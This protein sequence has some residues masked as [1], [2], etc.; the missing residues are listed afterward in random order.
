MGNSPHDAATDA[1]LSMQDEA[2]SQSANDMRHDGSACVEIYTTHVYFQMPVLSASDLVTVQDGAYTLRHHCSLLHH[3]LMASIIPWISAQYLIE[4]G[5]LTRE[6]ALRRQICLFEV[7]FIDVY[8]AFTRKAIMYT[9]A[10][11]YAGLLIT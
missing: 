5:Y 1:T 7:C 9:N 2:A 3:A 8:G 6:D 10:Y 11:G 4:V